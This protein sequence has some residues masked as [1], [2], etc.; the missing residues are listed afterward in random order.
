MSFDI[1]Y[2]F[3]EYQEKLST[4]KQVSIVALNFHLLTYVIFVSI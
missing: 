4:S 2:I 3:K 1:R